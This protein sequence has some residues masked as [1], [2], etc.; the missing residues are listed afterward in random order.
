M[1]LKQELNTVL[2]EEKIFLF[3]KWRINWLKLGDKNTKFF[4]VATMI[5]RQQNEV[6]SIK[7]P[8]GDICVDHTIME[9]EA[10]AFYK[11]LFTDITKTSNMVA[12]NLDPFPPID[13]DS[14]ENLQ[15]Q[16]IN[17]ELI[18][19]LKSTK[20]YY[21]PGPDSFQQSSTNVIGIL[22]N[23]LSLTLSNKP[24]VQKE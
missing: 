14:F 21:A 16:V 4:Y 2:D 23:L 13:S 12:C 5:Q 20:S 6:V 24:S 18:Q 17:E 15:Q 7:L 8:S 22:L 9:Q 3:Q 1:Q 11:K 19:A 10:L